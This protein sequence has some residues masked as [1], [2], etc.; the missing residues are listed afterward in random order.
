MV[1][2]RARA[3]RILLGQGSGGIAED[4][5]CQYPS[6]FLAC[7]SIQAPRLLHRPKTLSISACAPLMNSI[8]A[9][10]EIIPGRRSMQFSIHRIKVMHLRIVAL[11]LLYSYQPVDRAPLLYHAE[12]SR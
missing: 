12:Q 9:Q 8:F 5:C 7:A 2:G 3:V 11:L 4:F 1:T 6:S 10:L